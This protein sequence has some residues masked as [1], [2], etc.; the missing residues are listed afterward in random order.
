MID[1][2][3][4]APTIRPISNALA[5]TALD[6]PTRWQ[7]KL[8]PLN[9]IPFVEGLVRT[10]P[11]PTRR[12]VT[13]DEFTGCWDD[14]ARQSLP[15][16]FPSGVHDLMPGA[17]APPKRRHARQPSRKE[18]AANRWNCKVNGAVNGIFESIY[19]NVQLAEAAL[20][21]LSQMPD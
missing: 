8:T 3:R 7:R 2:Y 4:R 20:L 17:Q 6:G 9:A 18:I 13:R 16:Y 19:H 11:D 5:P 14:Y 1:R 15:M 10:E 21:F 12:A